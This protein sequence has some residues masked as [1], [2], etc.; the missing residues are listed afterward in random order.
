[1]AS[2]NNPEYIRLKELGKSKF[3]VAKNES[4]IRGWIVKNIDG[5]MLGKVDDLLFDVKSEKV[6]YMVLDLVGNEMYLK[7]RKVIAPLSIAEI[8]EGFKNVIYPG[9]MANE[10]TSLPTYEKGKVSTRMEDMVQHA[11]SGFTNRQLNAE[12]GRQEVLSASEGYDSDMKSDHRNEQPRD[13]SRPRPQ[14]VIG[15][16]EHSNQAQV[17][18]EYL[19][20]HDFKRN[21][22]EVSSRAA[23]QSGE[24]TNDEH[25]LTNWFKSMF[26]NENDARTYSEAARTGC[27]VTIQTASFEEAERAAQILDKHG[28]LNINDSSSGRQRSFRSRILDRKEAQAR[29]SR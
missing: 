21:Q 22:I 10:L 28:A 15:V 17:A 26:G 6:L 19:L 13:M 1:M 25:S 14:T 20:D 29:W 2:G 23:T 24:P 18:I 11:F 5:R 9:M 27:V 16:F 3:E 12:P 7:E 4:D 8:H